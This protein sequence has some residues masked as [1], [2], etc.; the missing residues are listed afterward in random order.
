MH[1]DYDVYVLDVDGEYRVRPAVMAVKHHNG[2]KIR[3]LTDF[4]ITVRFESGL[5]QP[6][7][8]PRVP[9]PDFSQGFL[10]EL[11]QFV[12]S[13]TRVIE[14]HSNGHFYFAPGR[15]GRAFSYEV[16]VQTEAGPVVAKGESG[17]KIIVDP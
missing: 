11:A 10:Q 8:V 13:P 4:P 1:G 14:A 3:N 9:G 17:P 6:I 12:L 7:V 15:S 5:L 16:E 2:V